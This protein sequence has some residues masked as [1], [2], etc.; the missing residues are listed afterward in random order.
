MIR[1][2]TTQRLNNLRKELEK[3]G[4]DAFLVPS[5]DSHQS[6]YVAEADKRL[7]WISGFSGTGFAAI[8]KDNAALCTDGRY[9]IQAEDQLDCN[10]LFMKGREGDLSKWIDWLGTQLPENAK[11]GADPT[12][13]GA[14][15]W[16][17]SWT[18]AVKK[19]HF[20]LVPVSRNLIDNIWKDDSRER[21]KDPL[22]IL[23]IKF[24]G[25]RWQQKVKDVLES[26][27]TLK[28]DAI[29]VSAL[30]EIAWL[31][32]L[33]G[34]DI[35]YN[36]VFRGYAII[37]KDIKEANLNDSPKPVLY[38]Y[39]PNDKQ[40]IN[41]KHHLNT[42]LSGSQIENL[43]GDSRIAGDHLSNQQESLY[44][45][46]KDYDQIFNDLPALIEKHNWNS[47]LLGKRIAYSGGASFAIYN[48]IPPN[49]DEVIIL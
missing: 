11:I 14:H 45:R 46:L 20:E 13:T 37:G 38:L 21:N 32:N 19:Y 12:L 49:K 27:D 28:N 3:K 9:F 43:D 16:I 4:L 5:G 6:E 41:I 31:F 29:I 18:P 15:K 17:S 36:P 34:K 30:D 10:W 2:N 25:R 40:D 35:P 39:L 26:L 7:K 22:E 42:D 47:V 1:V 44:V 48:A 8:T 23:D 33:R 24:S